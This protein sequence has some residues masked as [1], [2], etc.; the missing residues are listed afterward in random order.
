MTT[1]ARELLWVGV[2]AVL[3]LVCTVQLHRG[4]E[5]PS[6]PPMLAWVAAPPPPL[7]APRCGAVGFPGR[8]PQKIVDAKP[9][10]PAAARHAGVTGIVIISADIDERGDVM[11]ARVVRSIPTLD[12]AALDAVRKWR[13]A[14]AA[15]D[16][17]PTCVTMTLTVEFDGHG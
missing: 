17:V 5:M 10:Y 12:Q 9:A 4:E 6:P 11:N 3:L 1:G 2:V 16:G 8:P 14:P 13:F 15:I 7:A